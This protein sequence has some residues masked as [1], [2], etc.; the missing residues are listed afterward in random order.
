LVDR[1][2]HRDIDD[3]SS[4]EPSATSRELSALPSAA[5]RDAL[6]AAGSPLSRSRLDS[7]ERARRPLHA[8]KRIELTAD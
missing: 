3:E 1:H 8:P 4:G 6:K 5:S 2:G 7:P